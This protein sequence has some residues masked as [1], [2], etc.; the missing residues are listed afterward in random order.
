M[1]IFSTFMQKFSVALQGLTR[2][3]RIWR[4]SQREMEEIEKAE[5]GRR[6]GIHNRKSARAMGIK[7]EMLGF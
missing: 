2:V 5:G 3:G 4:I 6:D 1:A 7:L